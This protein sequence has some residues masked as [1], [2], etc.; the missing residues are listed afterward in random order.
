MENYQTANDKE[1]VER[2]LNHVLE[3]GKAIL[4]AYAHIT[5]TERVGMMLAMVAA[6]N[7]VRTNIRIVADEL[8]QNLLDSYR[9]DYTDYA[10]SI[11]NL[12]KVWEEELA[13]APMIFNLDTSCRPLTNPDDIVVKED[14][15]Y[16]IMLE[17][18]D[19]SFFEARVGLMQNAGIMCN[20]I[21]EGLGSISKSL[22]SIVDD[23]NNLKAN[24]DLQEEKL[25]ILKNF[26]EEAMWEED[27]ARLVKEADEY[28]MLCK[29]NG[30]KDYEYYLEHIKRKATDPHDNKVLAELNECFLAGESTANFI[31]KNRD[32]LTIEDLAKHFCFVNSHR[33][34]YT[35]I[36]MFNLW[37]PADSKY[38]ILF[39]NKAAQ[40]LAIALASTIGL[41]VD[42][43]YNYQYAALQMAMMDLGLIYGDKRNGVQMMD[44]INTYYLKGDAIKDQT[45][46]TQWTGKLL[47]NCFGKIDEDNLGDTSFG[48]I[49]YKKIKDLYWLCLSIINK[50]IQ[51]D[52]QERGFAPYLLV[53]HSNTPSI[54]D[55]KNSNKESI[56]ER[57]FVLKSAF[58]RETIFN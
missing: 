28:I 35:H 10:R 46:L 49:D 25:S 48:I 51:M 26:Y 38:D 43:R 58:N 33:L 29:S 9:I 8:R 24:I 50:V 42:F 22:R 18:T 21:E 40:E 57:L 2:K 12:H 14:S 34:V 32:K 15:T 13:G 47:G 54:T 3:M 6:V 23:Y 1:N 4:E 20:V 37:Q 41:Y 44:Y 19:F 36:E 30:K 39:T 27:E 7:Q 5:C 31:V 56:M 16:G 55:Y 45:T 17:T 52:L 53:D 11:E